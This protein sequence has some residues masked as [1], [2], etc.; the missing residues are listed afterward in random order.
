MECCVYEI[1]IAVH[2]NGPMIM[3]VSQ[4]KAHRMLG[5]KL[6][7]KV[8]HSRAGK[9]TCIL[10]DI[11]YAL[12]DENEARTTSAKES[13]SKNATTT[14]NGQVTQRNEKHASNSAYA[15]RK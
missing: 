10:S 14:T 7:A 13:P 11:Q 6:Q 3:S 2:P 9:K 12:A 15:A 8:T 1:D 4:Q 5:K